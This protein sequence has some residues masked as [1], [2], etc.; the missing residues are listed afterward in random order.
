MLYRV[1]LHHT[2]QYSSQQFSHKPQSEQLCVCFVH[3][4]TSY[5]FSDIPAGKQQISRLGKSKP[6]IQREL[7]NLIS[8]Q[9]RHSTV[10]CPNSHFLPVMSFHLNL[11]LKTHRSHY[12]SSPSPSL[13]LKITQFELAV[14]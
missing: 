12:W 1:F 10:F 4:N 2:D 14:A 3:S 6:I 7:Q 11:N 5:L 9:R 8:S 13:V